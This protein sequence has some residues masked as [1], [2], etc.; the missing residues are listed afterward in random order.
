MRRFFLVLISALVAAAML[1]GFTAQAQALR[2]NAGFN[3]RFI[4]R[5][6]DGSSGLEPL[7]FTINFFGKE[8]SSAYV[9]NNGNITF[10]SALATFTPFGLAKTEREI[11]APFFADVD[12]RNELSKVVTYGQD[13]VNGHAAFGVNW[14]QVGYYA[15]HADKLNSFQ[16]VLVDRRDTG[17]GNFDIEFNY[18]Q[19]RW[20]TGDASGGVNGF[21]GTPAVVGWSN[22][23][24]DAY[25]LLGSMVS[26]AF[27][28]GGPR[29]LVRQTVSGSVNPAQSAAGTQGRLT[30]RA[31]D[32]IIGPGLT[33]TNGSI[34]PEATLGASYS[35]SLQAKGAD[36]PFKWTLT[37]DINMA[38]GLTFN[39]ASGTLSGVPTAVGT[40]SFTLSVTAKT[41][42]GDVTIFDRGSIT[43]RPP[44]VSITTSCP[45]ADATVGKPYSVSL[46]AGG[47]GGSYTW[48]VEDPYSL[49]PGISLS[50]AGLFAGIPRLPGTYLMN[51]I[52]RS[53]GS[54]DSPVAQSRCRINVAPAAVALTSGCS[55]LATSGVPFSQALAPAGGVAPYKFDLIGQL[56]FGLALTLEGSIAG[57]PSV[58][59]VYP[60]Q[61][62]VTDAQRAQTVQ[63]CSMTVS[64]PA[65]SV[66]GACPLPSGI[67]G[68]PYSA[69]LPEGYVW[70]LSSGVIPAGLKLSPDGSISGIPMTAGPARFG[71]IA[72]DPQGQQAGVACS[73]PVMRGPLSING[74]PLP[75]ANA[76]EP[77]SATVNALGGSAPYFFTVAGSLP[78][79]LDLSTGG[80]LSGSTTDSGPHSFTVLV[81]EA[82]GQTATQA[83]SLNVARPA[84][85][86]ASACPLPDAQIGESYAARIDAAG[87]TAPYRFEFGGF[88]PD[89][90]R[91]TADGAVRGVPSALG[92]R[93][94]S[95]K[96][97][98]ARNQSVS[99]TCSLN[100]GV[101]K[102]PQVRIGTLPATVAS[103]ASNFAIPVE[104]AEAYSQPVDGQLALDIQPNTRSTEAGGN[105]PD[106]RLRFTNGQ[107]IANFSIPAGSTRVT[108]PLTSTGT[109]ASTVYVSVANLKISGAAL[110][111]FPTPRSF[112]IAPAI[113][114]VTSACYTRIATGIDIVINGLSNTRELKRVD[115]RVGTQDL[116]TELSGISAGYYSSAETIRAGGT[117][118]LHVPYDVAW[119]AAPAPAP[120]V[121]LVLQNTVGATGKISAAACP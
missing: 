118:S 58:S 6:D 35:V 84:L 67:T 86:I 12:T 106:P 103:A 80:I 23:S 13:T 82:Q 2:S 63:S 112:N 77:Y 115:V 4:P 62:A 38:P 47:A 43:I 91:G 116:Y 69:N 51:F 32:G 73:L 81:R 90:L 39:P 74:C 50:P 71:L 110:P 107:T 108:V 59:G 70:S 99:G 25:E 53:N 95:I 88:L 64:E 121:S 16:L 21:G 54:P 46:R 78:A 104:L 27:L 29:A 60:F 56:P 1:G 49:P 120:A 42:D 57:M 24:S 20:E 36:G 19:I 7:G 48:G 17:A 79:G 18:Q 98:D 40:Y 22:G 93:T 85:R 55:L 92:G 52:A 75:D 14:V 119:P 33:I 37:P 26:G 44:N 111:Q 8:R 45:L 65:F 100:V 10:D 28:D 66:D 3:S 96:V 11:I 31:R 87:G 89:G 5:N 76:G 68:Y 114:T 61:V 113:P 94:F 72:T 117:F 34:L 9:N 101:P 97:T 30:F 109:V 15:S 105:Q 41:E 83:C 102:V